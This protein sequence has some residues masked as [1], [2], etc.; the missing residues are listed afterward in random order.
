[1]AIWVVESQSHDDIRE[2][3]AVA[4]QNSSTH[5][6]FIRCSFNKCGAALKEV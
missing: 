1:M 3:L 6:R 5:R 2:S 4:A